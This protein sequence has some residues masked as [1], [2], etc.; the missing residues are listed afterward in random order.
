MHRGDREIVGTLAITIIQKRIVGIFLEFG[1]NFKKSIAAGAEFG[2]TIMLD[3]AAP[4][5]KSRRSRNLGSGGKGS[6]G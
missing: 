3:I 1:Q 5:Q 4:E 2:A 6:L